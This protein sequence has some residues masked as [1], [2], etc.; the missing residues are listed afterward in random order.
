MLLHQLA[1]MTPSTTP[2]R[3]YEQGKPYKPLVSLIYSDSL[4]KSRFRLNDEVVGFSAQI[5]D[6]VA[7]LV[8]TLEGDEIDG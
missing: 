8:I 2:I 6:G 5:I 1:K 4:S 7:Y 3:I